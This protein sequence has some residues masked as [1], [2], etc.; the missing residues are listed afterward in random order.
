MTMRYQ[1]GAHFR[2]AT[3]LPHN[4]VA[5]R[6]P[7]RSFPY[8]RRLPLVGDTDG[9][10]FARADAR[11]SERFDGHARLRL[12]DFI[13]AVLDPPRSG[14]D[15]LDFLLRRGNDGAAVVE[16][17]GSRTGRALIERQYEL[18]DLRPSAG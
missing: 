5:D 8:D 15:L 7:R 2:R 16:D 14:K 3:V 13:R 9:G 4:C 18:H 10:D 1:I 17:D 11:S 12:P 6:T